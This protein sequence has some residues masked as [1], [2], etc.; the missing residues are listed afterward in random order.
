MCMHIDRNNGIHVIT[1]WL[2]LF[3]FLQGDRGERGPVGPIGVEGK[4][5]SIC[6]YEGSK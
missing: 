5:V 2:I 1:S 4:A 3:F 6:L